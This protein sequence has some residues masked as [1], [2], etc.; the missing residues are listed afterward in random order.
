MPI[1]SDIF[2]IE[3]RILEEKKERELEDFNIDYKIINLSKERSKNDKLLNFKLE[4][5]KEERIEE[6]DLLK[7]HIINLKSRIEKLENDN[8]N[9]LKNGFI[10]KENNDWHQIETNY[11][12]NPIGI[13]R[14]LPPTKIM[15]KYKKCEIIYNIIKDTDNINC[16]YYYNG[17]YYLPENK[18]MLR[19]SPSGIVTMDYIECRVTITGTYEK[20]NLR[21]GLE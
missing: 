11:N 2:G 5:Q 9:I 8:L 4:K 6:N 20:N 12:I 16:C 19:Y 13:T 18:R 15:L 10:I 7:M 14:S 21:L 17:Y 3:D 1:L